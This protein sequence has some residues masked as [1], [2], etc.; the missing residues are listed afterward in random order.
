VSSK[1]SKTRRS[2]GATGAPEPAKESWIEQTAS[3]VGFFIYLLILKS[4][5]LPLFIIPTGSEADT[6]YGEHTLHTCPNCG[7]EYAIGWQ[8][9]QN[10][11]LATPYQPVIQC[12]NCRWREHYG[13]PR[14]PEPHR[15]PPDSF[16]REPLRLAAGDRIFVH[17]WA[18]DPPFA[19][20]DRFGPQRWDIVV[21]KVPTDG[22]TNYIKRL[23][24]LPNEKIELIDGDVFVNDQIAQKTPDAQRPLWFPY[25][26]HDYPP[27]AVAERAGYHPRW[28][29]LG[30]AGAWSGLETRVVRFEG[31]R[32]ARSEIQF[33]TD[34][35]NT[36]R[37]GRVQD[38]YDY[39]E[40][41]QDIGYNT[42]SDVRLAADIELT[43]AERGYVELS[44]TK[45]QHRF[46]ARFGSAGHLLVEHQRT[47]DASPETW[48]DRPLPQLRGPVRVALSH[49]DGVVRVEVNQ[50]TVFES[51]PAQ[52]EITPAIAAALSQAET[53]PTLRIA[54]ENVSA[55]LRHLVIER[56]IYYTSDVRIGPDGRP[57]HGVQGNPI[58]LG[59]HDYFVLGDNSPN[60]LDSRF[61]FSRPD[62]DPVGA[63]L[64]EAYARGEF[65]CGTVPGDQMIGRAFF[66]YWP[67]FLPLTARGPNLLP[68]LG[69]ARWIR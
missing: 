27:R 18:Y 4:F 25:Y 61:A 51:T 36:T 55:T 37:P 5:F 60:S 15:T 63:H 48:C 2:D 39:N 30:G 66:V 58:T 38:V 17:G 12:P 29:A 52:Y 35:Q 59:P 32:G 54:A 42:V 50:D 62:Q 22:Q 56:D 53:A 24:G 57:G 7:T 26:N 33:V 34:P 69:R 11:R 14:S 10:W 9:P 13:D 40:P 41:R 3:F 23:I 28:V 67:G 31:A 8:P 46:S 68:D 65:Q 43:P 20:L 45:G 1:P 6:L 49:V 44:T 19:G 47:P 16:L 21:F 64:K